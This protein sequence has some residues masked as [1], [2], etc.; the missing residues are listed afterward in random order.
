MLRNIGRPSGLYYFANSPAGGGV[1]RLGHY[2]KGMQADDIRFVVNARSSHGFDLSDPRVSACSPTSWQRFFNENAVVRSLDLQETVVFSHGAPITPRCR[3]LVLH[4]N[5]A[6]PLVVGEVRLSWRL[7]AKML[8][9]RSR[10]QR[11][12]ERADVITVES[13]ATWELVRC[14]WGE[15][16]AAKCEILSNGVDLLAEHELPTPL[17]EGPYAL[18]IGTYSY[19][20]LDKVLNEFGVLRQ[21][22]PGL[23][24]VVVGTTPAHMHILSLEGVIPFEQLSY[25]ATRALIARCKFYL[26]M[27]E[28]EN[29]SV[30]LLE[31][32]YHRRS[33]RVSDIP[34]HREFLDKHGYGLSETPAGILLGEPP[35]RLSVAVPSWGEISAA[36]QR[37]MA[38]LGAQAAGEIR[39]IAPLSGIPACGVNKV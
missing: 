28:I 14:N 19:K 1:V 5:N 10:L 25:L 8:L 6:L 13:E 2:L 15:A 18:T 16:I 22:H 27:S 29:C 24:L 20:R 21:Q 26:S 35:S 39:T 4:I 9:L 23:K 12:A 36:T 34:S 17:V 33:V 30:A 38:R 11:T 32:I 7:R 3:G 37:L 31:A